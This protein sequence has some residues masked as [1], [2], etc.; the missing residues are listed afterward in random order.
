M[1]YIGTDDR[2]YR[3]R[4]VKARKSL[5]ARIK[6]YEKMMSN[7]RVPQEYTCPGSM[8]CRRN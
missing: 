4:A 6:H 7:T 8:K 2:E 1:T 3:G 5:E